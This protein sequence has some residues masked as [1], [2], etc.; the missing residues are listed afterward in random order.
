MN[1]PESRLTF[2]NKPYE[3][4]EVSE[5][6]YSPDVPEDEESSVEIECYDD[7]SENIPVI[8]ATELHS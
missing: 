6:R 3:V 8:Q 4:V 2:G 7:T 5:V 1:E